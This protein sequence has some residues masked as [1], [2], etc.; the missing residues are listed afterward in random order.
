MDFTSTLHKW[1]A[2]GQSD[3]SELLC[4]FLQ[5]HFCVVILSAAKDLHFEFS[6]NAKAG[7]SLRSG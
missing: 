6:R 3:F 7:P 5:R 4:E 1:R 2:V